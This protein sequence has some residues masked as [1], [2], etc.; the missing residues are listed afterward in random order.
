MTNYYEILGISQN[1][2]V[3]E[4]R[5]AYMALALQFHPDKN[6]EPGAE[7]KFKEILEAYEVLSDPD[8]KANFDRKGDYSKFLK[9]D[10]CHSYFMNSELLKIHNEGFH[11]QTGYKCFM[12]G[13]YFDTN[14]DLLSHEPEHMN[15]W[16]I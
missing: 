1:A 2:S 8:K 16:P 5:K 9:C 13:E 7:E 15:S 3:C 12:C 6:K 14:E 4:I 11:A 10:S